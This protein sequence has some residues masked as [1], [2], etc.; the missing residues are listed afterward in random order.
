MSTLTPARTY[1]QYHIARK[2]T[3]GKRRVSIYW[4]WS[5]PWVPVGFPGVTPGPVDRNSAFARSVLAECMI[6]VVSTRRLRSRAHDCLL[7]VLSRDLS[8]KHHHSATPGIGAP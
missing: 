5:Y 4:T 3:P 8:F 7:S 2:Y 1:N 6:L